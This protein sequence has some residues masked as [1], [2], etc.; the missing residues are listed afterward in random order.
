MEVDRCF[1][2]SGDS[3]QITSTQDSSGRVTVT[4]AIQRARFQLVVELHL[5]LSHT[6]APW[7][8]DNVTAT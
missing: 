3:A 7:L 8:I 6:V 1:A 4:V 2:R 5:T